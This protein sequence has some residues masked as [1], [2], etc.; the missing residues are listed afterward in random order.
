MKR[1]IAL[2][3]VLITASLALP[4][5]AASQPLPD[6]TITKVTVAKKTVKGKAK[7]LVTYSVKNIGSAPAA[8][9]VTKISVQGAGLASGE[10]T[11]PPLKPNEVRQTSWTC[12]ISR[13]G[14]YK[15]NVG[16]DYYNAITETN[17]MNNQ[18][19]ISFGFSR[20]F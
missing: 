10:Q 18:N 6:L 15:I 1:T 20:P 14:K 4:V 2:L 17:K 7:L 16:A 12:D 9:S 5:L 11:C 3:T 19:Q 8:A 13:A